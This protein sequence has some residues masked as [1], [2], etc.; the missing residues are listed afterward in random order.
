MSAK[1]SNGVEMPL[2]GLG[3]WKMPEGED[4][5]RIIR[6]ALDMGYRHIDT[7]KMYGNEKS[8]GEA[9]RGSGISREEIFITT[10]LLPADIFRPREAFEE[11]LA[12][13][14]LP[15]V[16]L[17]LIHW[18][19]PMMPKSVWPALE[20]I[21]E[22][23]LARTI[24]VSNYSIADLEELRAYARA[25]PAVDQILCSPFQYDEELCAYCRDRGIVVEAYS[26]LTRGERL[27]DATVEKIAA[28]HGKTPAQ[29]MLRWCIEHEFMAIPKSANPSRLR[30]NMDIFDW[31][32]T[33]DELKTL[34]RLSGNAA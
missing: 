16:D 28:A 34:D 17:Y 1:L 20:S 7:A 5:V 11:S 13:L 26:P 27:N 22:E 3:T 4:T 15:Y 32:L 19:A 10:K 30:E 21:N 31:S 25:L 33:K 23:G 18:P 24:G 12:R 29:V 8:V 9:V 14:G 6:E 2:L